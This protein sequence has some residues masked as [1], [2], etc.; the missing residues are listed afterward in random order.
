VANELD[1]F[2]SEVGELVAKH[3]AE[4]GATDF[5]KYADD[6]AGFMRDVLR[7][8]PWE[9]QVT[10]AEMV[11]DNP[12]TVVVTANGIGKDWVSARIALWWV[13]ARRGFCILTAPTE[14]Q[15]KQIL[16]REIRRAFAIAPELPGELYALELRVSSDCGILA[17]TSD[18]ADKLTGFHHPRLL[19]CV[20]EGQG[21]SE[22]AY[23]AARACCT[24]PENRL[25][26]YGNPTNPVGPFYRAANSAGWSA[27]TVAATMH[28]N[29]VSGRAEIPGA[30]SR[31]WIEMMREEYGANS[32]IYH[33]RVLAQFPSESIEGL[34]S[35]EWLV[36]AAKRHTSGELL[37]EAKGKP[38]YGALDVSRFGGDKT[39]LTFVQGP[40][41]SETVTWQGMSIT[42][43]AE[44][45]VQN[46]LRV[47]NALPGGA[48]MANKPTIVVDTIGLGAGVYDILKSRGWPCK[49]FCG[50]NKASSRFL[51]LRAE[52]HWGFRELLE[53]GQVAIPHSSI[54]AE[55]CAAVEWQTT[56]AGQIQ[57]LSKD[58]IRKTLGRSPDV[59]DSVVMGLSASMGII[60]QPMVSFFNVS[61]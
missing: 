10:M 45:C 13:F 21:V 22:D 3:N 47:W 29:V 27:L 30:V 44:R 43:T 37:V 40:V 61:I 19:I 28:P 2:R 17:F 12:S 59:L 58:T 32:S 51:N 35:R 6:P 57:I 52:S 9:M 20:T 25:F 31:E 33:S 34:I 16:M 38:V 8:D 54:L 60:K 24:G 42:E 15:V 46:A 23:E 36:S 14:R 50:S 5:T 1:R 4:K 56:L 18:N 11:R 39:A 48:T 41:V 26:V 49:Q 7:C 55:E 53:R